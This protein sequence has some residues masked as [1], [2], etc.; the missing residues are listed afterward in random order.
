ML[1]TVVM[2]VA[3]AVKH[4]G[5]LWI[6]VGFSSSHLAIC[7]AENLCIADVMSEPLVWQEHSIKRCSV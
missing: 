1:A 5:N 3:E 6:V 2:L 7:T 4:L